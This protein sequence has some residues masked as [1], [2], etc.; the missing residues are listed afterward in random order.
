[1]NWPF[2]IAKRYLFAQKSSNAINI[3]SALSVLGIAIG[4]AALILVLSVFNGFEEVIGDLFSAFNPDVKI[5]P[6][7]GK[8]FELSPKLLVEL[9][10]LEGV[11]AVAPSLEEVAFF[12]YDNRQDFGIL[13]GVDESYQQV[14]GIDSS[15]FEGAFLLDDGSQYYAILGIGMRNK[16]SLSLTD[17][18]NTINVY[19]AKRKGGGLGEPFRR[20]R[21][22]PSGTFSIQQDFDNQYVLTSI[23]FM[24]SLLRKPN[25][26]SALEIKL[27]PLFSLT[28]TKESI[29]ELV[30]PNFQVKDRYEQD[31]AFL[32][33]M[34][35]EKWMSFAILCLT[36][37]LVAFNMI[38]AL[39]MIVLEKRK[40]ISILQALGATKADIRGLFLQEGGLLCGLGMLIG[41]A[42]ALLLYAIQINYGIISI[43]EGFVI[44]AY[45]ISIRGMDFIVVAITVFTIGLLASLPAAIR[46]TRIDASVRMD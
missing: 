38:G 26:A 25:A 1:M 5:L 39:W 46:A 8:T 17:E 7:S 36:L 9:K 40:D 41:F 4:T 45:P 43:P 6:V 14:T 42:L 29:Q 33:L 23:A 30:G 21:L 3:I 19:M 13:K 27:A 37:V 34:N 22:T 32:K 15:I 35:M 12:E 2:R 28:Q 16:L 10:E 44:N 18:F 24:Q 31:E 11:E 20:Q